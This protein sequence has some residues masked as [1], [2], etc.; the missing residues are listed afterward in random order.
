M[1]IQLRTSIV[2]WIASRSTDGRRC[3]SQHPGM[4]FA[5]WDPGCDASASLELLEEEEEG[6]DEEGGGVVVGGAEKHN[7]QIVDG[8]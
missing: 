1:D 6:K 8:Q 2:S 5:L 3:T 7:N 4:R